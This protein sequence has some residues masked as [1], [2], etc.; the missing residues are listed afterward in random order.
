MKLIND[1]SQINLKE[2]LQR[3]Y[4]Q[5][6]LANF[7]AFNK[8]SLLRNPKKN[9]FEKKIIKTATLYIPI[10]HFTFLPTRKIVEISQSLF[11]CSKS[12][13]KTPEQCVKY[14]RN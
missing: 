3:K 14:V 5:R 12:E 2:Y 9:Y 1:T 8:I 7:L 6:V 10:Y 11:T 4:L 13:I